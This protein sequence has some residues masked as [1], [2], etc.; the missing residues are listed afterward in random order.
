MSTET[1]NAL[2]CKVPSLCENTGFYTVNTVTVNRI[3]SRLNFKC[4]YFFHLKCYHANMT[5]T[6][7]YI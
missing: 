7:C 1:L 5:L 4:I 2:Y 6:S 3:T